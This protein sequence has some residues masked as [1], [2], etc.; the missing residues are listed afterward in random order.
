MPGSGKSTVGVQLAKELGMSFVDTDILI[1]EQQQRCLQDIVNSE[2][3]LK[4]RQIEEDVLLGI[5]YQHTVIATGGS[6][7]YSE[8]AINHL[9]NN[10][11]IVFLEVSLTTIQQRITNEGTRGIAKPEGHTLDDVYQ[12]RQPLYT[13]YADVAY[14]N[15]QPTDISEL[16]VIIREHTI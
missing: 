7:V 2:G 3:Y 6:A 16:A 15:N 10:G 4:L 9:K 5:D 14:N 11:L 12:E 8:K 13:R 1:Q